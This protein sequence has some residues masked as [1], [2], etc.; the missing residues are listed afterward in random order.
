[1]EPAVLTK[2][3]SLLRLT[4]K[5]E[6]SLLWP[7]SHWSTHPQSPLTVTYGLLISLQLDKGL[8]NTWMHE[9]IKSQ[10]EKSHRNI[11]YD[12]A[13]LI[14]VEELWNVE[15]PELCLCRE[16]ACHAAAPSLQY[17]TWQPFRSHLE[18]KPHSPAP[19]TLQVKRGQRKSR[20]CKLTMQKLPKVCP[21]HFSVHTVGFFLFHLSSLTSLFG[22]FF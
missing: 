18:W 15:V 8:H 4:L 3:N 12:T 22:I 10:E 6:G 1:M 7:L 14:I 16:P 5:N 21:F 17:K 11:R 19:L 20:R 13:H 2:R 9:T